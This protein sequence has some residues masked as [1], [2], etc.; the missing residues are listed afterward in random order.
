MKARALGLHFEIGAALVHLGELFRLERRFEDAA[1]C[2][3]ESLTL[4]ETVG[5]DPTTILFNLA[6]AA[7]EIG[8]AQRAQECLR[9]ASS[10]ASRRNSQYQKCWLPHHTTALASALADHDFAAR[11]WGAAA[12]ARELSHLVLQFADVGYFETHVARSREA[13]GD[14]SFAAHFHAGRALSIEQAVQE[15]DDWLT[16]VA[17]VTSTRATPGERR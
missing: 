4:F 6:I 14:A 12:A 3:G 8:D 5:L 2:Y 7:T 16:R 15:I 1:R 11:M 9:N 17:P 13:L 10:E